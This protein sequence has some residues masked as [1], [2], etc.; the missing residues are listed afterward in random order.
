MEINISARHGHLSASTQER[1][2]EK[3]EKLS[4]Y[5]DRLTAIVVTVNLERRDNPS[6]EIRALIEHADA[7]VAA[8]QSADVLTALDGALHK[9]EQQIRRHKDRRTDRRKLPAKHMEVPDEAEPAAETQAQ[10]PPGDSA[11][12]AEA[13]PDRSQG[14]RTGNQ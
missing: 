12:D 8:D 10:S 3:V 9:I 4:R 2:R 1:I 11:T 7:L 13:L 14:E 6:L 5:F